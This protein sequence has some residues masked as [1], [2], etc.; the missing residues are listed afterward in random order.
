[1]A[2]SLLA[3]GANPNIA[4][5]PS[6]LPLPRALARHELHIAELL[7]NA[8]ADPNAGSPL[9]LALKWYKAHDLAQKLLKAGAT[10]ESAGPLPGHAAAGNGR[11]DILLWMKAQGLDFTAVNAA[12]QTMLHLAAAHGHAKTA[13]M[14]LDEKM[15]FHL[16]DG[17]GRSALHDAATGGHVDIVKMLLDKGLDINLADNE[18]QTPLHKAAQTGHAGMVNLLLSA[19]A[20]TDIVDHQKMS[21]LAFAQQKDS[22]PIISMLAAAEK[23]T[24]AK[25]ATPLTAGVDAIPE[26][27]AEIWVRLGSHQVARVGV[28]PALGR[29]LT[30][31]FN[32]ESRGLLVIAENLKTGAE[33]V[34]PLASFDTVSEAALKKAVSAFRE[35]GGKVDEASVFAR[36]LGKKT[37]TGPGG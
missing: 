20:R 10:L 18:G 12:G 7:L 2:S 17:T 29:K 8:K 11:T 1:M 37:L 4:D 25:S 30:E 36:Q 19:G 14:L 16:Q 33:S 24:R 27:D 3:A 15:D 6:R 31:I 28:Y 21:A 34:T 13:R 22:T 23:E 35:Q 5:D 9:G 26:S 32:F